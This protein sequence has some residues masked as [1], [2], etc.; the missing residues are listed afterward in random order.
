MSLH[1]KHVIIRYL[2]S[3]LCQWVYVVQDTH[4]VFAYSFSMAAQKQTQSLRLVVLVASVL[5]QCMPMECLFVHVRPYICICL[6]A[7]HQSGLTAPL[8]SMESS[9]IMCCPLLNI[10]SFW[11]THTH[12][13]LISRRTQSDMHKA[14]CGS[15]VSEASDIKTK[16]QCWHAA[17]MM[18]QGE[19]AAVSMH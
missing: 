11:H 16:W 5:T 12:T 15:S 17:V 6:F 8:P 14:H 3:W 19:N 7:R 9:V 18:Y 4:I 10:F 2:F 13:H 1:D